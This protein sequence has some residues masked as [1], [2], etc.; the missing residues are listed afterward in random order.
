[1]SSAWATSASTSS[2]AS[3]ERSTGTCGLDRVTLRLDLVARHLEHLGRGPDEDD[4]VG[5]G[6]LR[7]FRVLREEAVARVDRIRARLQ[8]DADDL[9]D[10]QVRADGV[11]AFAD[12]VSFVSLEPVDG[13][14]V[15]MR[16]DRDGARPHLVRSSEGPDRDLAAVGHKDLL[17]HAHL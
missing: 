12:L 10:V 11:T 15:L 13:S 8:G 3:V 17:E 6:L 5:R 1:M 4:A 2:D 7:E 9:V 14:A 16:E